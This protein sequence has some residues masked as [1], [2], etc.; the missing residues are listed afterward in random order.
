MLRAHG[1][2]LAGS[3]K[4]SVD[5]SNKMFVKMRFVKTGRATSRGK[6]VGT[7]TN[8]GAQEPRFKKQK[9]RFL[10]NPD[11]KIVPEDE[12]AKILKPCVYKLR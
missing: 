12:E 5:L 6:N 7:V 4:E 1:F 3:E 8:T 11:D 10:D 9:K 2:E